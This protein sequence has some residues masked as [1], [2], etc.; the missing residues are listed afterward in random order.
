MTNNFLFHQLVIAIYKT[1]TS[2]SQAKGISL[3]QD[4]FGKLKVNLGFSWRLNK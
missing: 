3:I 1:E 4:Y 2:H